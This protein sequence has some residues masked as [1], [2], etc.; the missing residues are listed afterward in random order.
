MRMKTAEPKVLQFKVRCL[1]AAC[2][3][4][5]LLVTLIPVLAARH[6]ELS[7]WGWPLDF[8][9]AAQGCVLVYLLIVAVYASLVNHWERQA[10]HLSLKLVPSQDV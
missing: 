2:L 1:T 7:L 10:G 8:W 9:M 3:C 4:L 6:H 5:W